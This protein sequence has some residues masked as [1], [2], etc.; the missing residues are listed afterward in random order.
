MQ[1]RRRTP[2]ERRSTR[3]IP[4]VTS[5][6]HI[7]GEALGLALAQDLGEEGM[8]LRCLPNPEPTGAPVKLA[9]ELPDG[10]ELL[11]VEGA[12]VFERTDGAYRQTGV[13]FLSLSS[14]D[15]SR[16]AAYLEAAF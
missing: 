10:G 6:H 12:V 5:V 16:I 7:E 2:R 11:R 4:F 1:D 14:Q 8:K 15:R 13:R 3:R 9:F